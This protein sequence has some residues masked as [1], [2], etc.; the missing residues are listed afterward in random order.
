MTAVEPPKP[1]RW[2]RL[3]VWVAMAVVAWLA[4][5]VWWMVLT[6]WPVPTGAA[7]VTG[8]AGLAAGLLVNHR[9]YVEARNEAAAMAERM[10]AYRLADAR[11]DLDVVGPVTGEHPVVDDTGVGTLAYLQR[12]PYDQTGEEPLCAW[13]LEGD[14]EGLVG[15]VDMP[16]GTDIPACHRHRDDARIGYV[17]LADAI[18]DQRATTYET[19]LA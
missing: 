9:R 5:A 7:T 11:T 4:L 12:R 2:A 6:S 13:A 18:P 17:A 8:V 15:R 1:P 14:C 19:R 16:G 10:D 3:A